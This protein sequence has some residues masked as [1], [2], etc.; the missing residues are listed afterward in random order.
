[1][2]GHMSDP[3]SGSQT[4]KNIS[5]CKLD[6]TLLLSQRKMHACLIHSFILIY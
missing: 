2:A 3:H 1:M 4:R 6:K 5:M